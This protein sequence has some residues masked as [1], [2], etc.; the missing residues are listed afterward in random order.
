MSKQD[1]KFIAVL[2]LFQ[3]SILL[4]GISLF[5]LYYSNKIAQW[6]SYMTNMNKKLKILRE[7]SEQYDS[8][9]KLKQMEWDYS[10]QGIGAEEYK[11]KKKTKTNNKINN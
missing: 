1:K 8:D 6:R 2:M 3:T 5:G 10:I 7:I 9:M 11:L 4:M